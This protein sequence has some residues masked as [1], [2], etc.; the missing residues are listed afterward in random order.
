MGGVAGARGVSK[1][2]GSSIRVWSRPRES[3]AC[4]GSNG[5]LRERWNGR[6][7]KHGGGGGAASASAAAPGRGVSVV[8]VLGGGGGG[9]GVD[10]GAPG[11]DREGR[12]P[13]V[14]AV[15]AVA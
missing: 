10:P 2:S 11:S 3:R 9:G 13:G 15:A 12:L 4:T 8:I 14:A 1:N 7:R 6:E 5:E